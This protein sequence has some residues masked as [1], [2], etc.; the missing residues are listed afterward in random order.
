MTSMLKV[1]VE[2]RIPRPRNNQESKACD[3]GMEVK[4]R[5]D[6]VGRLA[7]E[8]DQLDGVDLNADRHSM[9]FSGADLTKCPSFGQLP[10]GLF[11]LP[12]RSFEAVT[13]TAEL[14]PK[15]GHL[16]KLDVELGNDRFGHLRYVVSHEG[17]W[18]GLAKGRSVY[19]E[20][21]PSATGSYARGV[22]SVVQFSDSE[23][24]ISRVK[25][26]SKTIY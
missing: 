3:E 5:A 24:Q 12:E 19:Q 18:M 17:T 21:V 13:G 1:P 26:G 25:G 9:V 4:R 23:W 15:T 10:P 2:N 8:A 16:A 6:F 14:D 20:D 7:L 22:Q 11:S